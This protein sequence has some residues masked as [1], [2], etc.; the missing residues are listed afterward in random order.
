LFGRHPVQRGVA[1]DSSIVD[2][3]FNG[4]QVRFDAGDAV[5]ALLEIADIPFV[6]RNAAFLMERFRGRAVARVNR[7][8]QIACFVQRC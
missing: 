3:D 4:A 8:H 1:R 2:Q 5:M 6:D 7:G